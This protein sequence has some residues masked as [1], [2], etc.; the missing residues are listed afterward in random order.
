MKPR[1]AVL[2]S[3]H[4]DGIAQLDSFAV[5][6]QHLGVSRAELLEIVGGYDAVIVKSV[7]RMDRELIT[8]ATALKVIGRAGTGTEN[9]DIDFAAARG[10]RLL[11]VPTG[12]SVSAAEFTVAQILCLCRN[13][14]VA[15][16][17]VENGDFRRQPL[18]G[19]ELAQLTVAIVGLGNVGTE[20]A[21][22]LR[23]FGCRMIGYDPAPR[24]PEA[25]KTLGVQLKDSFEDVLSNADVLTFHVSLDKTTSGMLCRDALKHA[26]PGILVVNTSRG[27]VIDDQALLEALGNGQVAAAAV[28][29]IWPE[30]PFDRP[31]G[32]EAFDHPL[33]AHPRVYVTPH[34]AASTEDAQRRIA[35]DLA[36]QIELALNSG[37]GADVRSVEV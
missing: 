34:M 10:V 26:K 35:I 6:D 7:T 37:E 3:I 25:L 13:L 28:D 14:Y 29:V 18:E 19:R 1:I 22:R 31:P 15:R 8:R 33:L 4:R 21:R 24:Y 30:P 11:T 20:V 36:T 12:N 2:E 16:S 32:K 9:I 23:S 5:V 17:A 27:A